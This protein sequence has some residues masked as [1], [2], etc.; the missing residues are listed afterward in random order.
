MARETGFPQLPCKGFPSDHVPI[1]NDLDLFSVAPLDGQV[2]LGQDGKQP[3]VAPSLDGHVPGM[4][5]P[6]KPRHGLALP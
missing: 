6:R 2:A 4:G 3:K 1:I 5:L